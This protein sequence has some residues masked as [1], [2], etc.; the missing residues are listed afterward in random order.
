MSRVLHWPLPPV[1][2]PFADLALYHFSA[3]NLRCEYHGRLNPVRPLSKP[4]HLGLSTQLVW[5]ATSRLASSEPFRTC[6]DVTSPEASARFQG[7]PCTSGRPSS[8]QER[9]KCVRQVL[10]CE[11]TWFPFLVLSVC[12]TISYLIGSNSQPL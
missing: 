8:A 9:W 3:R 4:P 10:R 6:R 5:P 12:P 7:G 1:P 11:G 2:F